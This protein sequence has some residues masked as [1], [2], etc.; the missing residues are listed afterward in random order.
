[1]FTTAGGILLGV[2]AGLRHAFEPD[3]LTAVSTLVAEAGDARRGAL[4]GA[5]WGVGHTASLLVVGI[6][7]MLAGASLPAWAAAAFEFAVAIMLIVLGMRAVVRALREGK[8]GPFA[9]HRHGD[10]EHT[11][12]APVTH[13]HLGSVP[14][15][16][17]PL[18]IGIVHGLAGS[19]ALTALAFAEIHE[20]VP[21]LVYVGLFGLGSIGGMAVASGLAGASMQVL[22]CG[23]SARRRLSLATGTVAITVGIA[24][25]VPI[26]EM[27]R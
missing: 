8:T 10:I 24:W 6:M 1:M 22:A 17:R 23:Q 25:A 19:G 5:L 12:S 27:L 26:A 20:A 14:V 3:H 9:T 7:L 21:R 18:L 13:I 15:A 16:W 2:L 4:L 11:H